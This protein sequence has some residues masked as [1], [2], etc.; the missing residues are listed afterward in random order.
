MTET[1]LLSLI[2]QE[3][4]QSLST[5]TGKLA[6]QR[7][8][9]I[10]YYNGEPYG[11]EVEGRSQVVTSEVKDAVEGIMPVLMSIFCSADEIVRFEPQGP[12]DEQSA[13]QATDYINYL[14]TRANRGVLSLYCLFK[15]ALLLKNGFLK[16]Y[17]DESHKVTTETYEDLGQL[18]LQL[19]LQDPELELI[20]LET[21]EDADED[22]QSIGIPPQTLYNAKFKRTQKEGKVCI[23]PVPPEEVLISRETTNFLTQAR[24]VEH[25]TR[26][27]LSQI[28]EM[29]YDI[30]D[31][32]AD[33]A[34]NADFNMERFERN[35]FD[36]AWA[37]QP[38]SGNN[39]PSSRK[40]WFC[41]A[42]MH[43]DYDGDGIAEFRRICKVGRKIL[44]NEE[45]DSHSIIGGTS[46]LAPHKF[47]GYSL[48]DLVGDIQLIKSTVTR[49][50][51]DNAYL[52]NNGRYAVLDGMVNMDD[53]LTN[54]PGGIV[55]MKSLGAV[56]RLDTPLLGQPAFNLLEYLDQM[57]QQRVGM[58]NFPNAVD[59]NAINAKAAFVETY[60][61][62]AMERVNLMAR[63]L[64]EG[65]VK[66]L[67]WK[68]FELVCK[69][70]DKPAMVKLRNNWVQIDPREWRNKFNMTVSVGLGTGSQEQVMKG[71]ELIL[72]GQ[73]LALQAGMGDRVVTE[74]NMYATLHRLAKSVFP[75]D[76]DMFFTNPQGLPPK[77]PPPPP[78]GIL[79]AQ[80][81]AQSQQA[82][83][84]M[85]GQFDMQLNAAKRQHDQ[86]KT[87][88]REMM[89]QQDQAREQQAQA[90]QSAIQAD[91]DSR[92]ELLSKM[93]ELRKSVAETEA[94]EKADSN[95]IILQGVVD[96]LIAHQEHQHKKMEDVLKT[97]VDASLRPKELVKE[98]GKKIVR[99][100]S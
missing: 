31:D 93:A 98:G 10:A 95:K 72:Q 99:P 68:I 3:E 36:D 63:V 60:K 56:T 89:A 67:F 80:I 16:V 26:K 20:E 24:F 40:V 45:W 66:D 69:H 1:E 18:E 86:E 77:Q 62:A 70:Q 42:Y 92:R 90:I 58:T 87:V 48:H 91:Q 14:F 35:K 19:L 2:E 53:L 47:Y 84:Q 71:A 43:V 33:Y 4:G 88:F 6:E 59:P 57:K 73:Q 75:K 94:Q 34:P 76:A 81:A 23:D 21:D 54:R 50:L 25:R 61:Q 78:E 37:Y 51:L 74:Q 79:K 12:E 83:T 96:S 44:A 38:D 32:L 11:N 28:R 17:W 5:T 27:S 8:Q 22:N 97:V 52:A 65:P 13:Q 15:D 46:I 85:Q 41:E 39:D 55:R 30:P 7:R 82:V 64:A 9:A 29:G 49:Q 100:V